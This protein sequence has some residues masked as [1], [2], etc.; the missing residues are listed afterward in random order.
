MEWAIIEEGKTGRES[1]LV[2]LDERRTADD[3]ARE[4]RLRGHRVDVRQY[5]E[6]RTSRAHSRRADVL[7]SAAGQEPSDV[8]A[9]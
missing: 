9:S 4:I 8:R 5:K 1:I 3:I 7:S 6:P 2:I